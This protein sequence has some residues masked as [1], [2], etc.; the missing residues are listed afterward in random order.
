[1][2]KIFGLLLMVTMLFGGCSTLTKNNTTNLTGKEYVLVQETGI[3]NILIGFDGDNFYGFSGVNNYFGKYEKKGSKI[4][5]DR[6]GATLMAGPD[7]LMEMEQNYFTQLEEVK[8]YQVN[9]DSLILTLDSGKQLV[10]K[11][12][13]K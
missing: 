2:K 6:M 4:K 9:G 8:S 1:M 10:F 11:E 5:L 7:R 3:P 12:N 13:K